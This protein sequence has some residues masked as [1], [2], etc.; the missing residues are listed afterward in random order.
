MEERHLKVPLFQWCADSSS[1]HHTQVVAVLVVAPWVV[2]V[3]HNNR[4]LADSCYRGIRPVVQ[5]RSA[6]DIGVAQDNIGPAVK[7]PGA[8]F[9]QA[10][11]GVIFVESPLLLQACPVL[12][13][14]QVFRQRAGSPE[15]LPGCS[16]WLALSRHPSVVEVSHPPRARVDRCSQ[17]DT[18]LVEGVLTQKPSH[19]CR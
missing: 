19:L 16:P 2:P 9:V 13:S 5:N 18:A 15:R 1:G 4:R 6:Q 3:N 7:A 17:H 10:S 8:R 12:E 11:P 14:W